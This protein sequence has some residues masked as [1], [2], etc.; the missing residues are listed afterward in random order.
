M[1]YTK[2]GHNFGKVD[3]VCGAGLFYHQFNII[4]YHLTLYNFFPMVF[5]RNA[6]TIYYKLLVVKQ[7]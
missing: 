7:I 6:L 2:S 4:G 3:K 5:Q 1:W